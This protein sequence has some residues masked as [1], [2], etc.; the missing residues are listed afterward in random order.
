M[1]WRASTGDAVGKSGI[2]MLK[3]ARNA[4]VVSQ[5]DEA[6]S[7]LSLVES[8]ISAD[9]YREAFAYVE[10]EKVR[11]SSIDRI[12]RLA[13][14]VAVGPSHVLH[15]QIELRPDGYLLLRECQCG[16]NHLCAHGLALVLHLLAMLAVKKQRRQISKQFAEF[17]DW[18]V[19]GYFVR[20]PFKGDAVALAQRLT[21]SSIEELQAYWMLLDMAARSAKPLLPPELVAV[22]VMQLYRNASWV[23][24]RAAMDAM[25]RR[26]N[27]V[28]QEK[29]KIY[30]KPDHNQVFGVYRVQRKGGDL[31]PYE[32]ALMGS[33]GID[34]GCSCPD[35]A[36]NALHFC[37]HLGAVLGH[38]YA[39]KSRQQRFLTSAGTAVAQVRW[40]PPLGLDR[41][42][43]PLQGLLLRDGG[44]V[45]GGGFPRDRVSQE[46]LALFVQSA[47]GVWRLKSTPHVDTNL[48]GRA[49]L[50]ENLAQQ[51]RRTRKRWLIDTSVLPML[52]RESE[53]IAWP[54]EYRMQARSLAKKN[55]L[56]GKLYP[57]QK[58]GVQRALE[59]GRFLLGD[60]M[61]LGKT[62]QGISWAE[63]LLKGAL[64]RRVV[65]ICPA[66][67]KEQWRREWRVASGRQV[68]VVEGWP[69]E[70]KRIY[71]S[72]EKVLLVNYELLLRDFHQIQAIA[73][74]AVILDEAQRIKNYATQTAQLVKRLTPRFRL[75]LTGTPME[76]RVA[77]LCSLMD[78]VDNGAM[79]P[80]WRIDAELAYADGFGAGKSGVQG[81]NLVRE[82]LRP[83]FLRRRRDEVLTQLPPR[84]D[85][86]MAVEVT[87]EQLSIHGLYAHKV[88]KLMK[89]TENRPLTPEEHLL[90]MSYLTQMRIVSNG[91]AQFEF[92]DLWPSLKGDTS[93]GK[94]IPS[95]CSPKLGVFRSL[96]EGFLPQN[97]VK[98]VIFSQWQRMLHLAHWAIHD[99]LAESGTEAVFFTGGESQ[100]RRTENIV[101][102]HDDPSV[103]LFFA[104]DAGGVGLNLQKA[105][106]VCFNLELPWNPAVLEQRVGRI[107]RLGQTEPVQI[108]NLI[109]EGTIE[110]RITALVGR[111]R[112]LFN[113]LFDGTSNEVVFDD[114][115]NFY[116]QMGEVMREFSPAGAASSD[117]SDV[118]EDVENEDG[119]VTLDAIADEVK[120]IAA[121]TQPADTASNA[122][123]DP[124]AVVKRSLMDGGISGR[125]VEAALSQEFRPCGEPE[126]NHGKTLDAPSRHEQPL[127]DRSAS[128]NADAGRV[129][130]GGDCPSL[131]DDLAEAFRGIR[132]QKGAAGAIRLEA[133]GSSAK[134][135]ADVFRGLASMF[136]HAAQ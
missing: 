107:Y 95:L 42:D 24:K 102:F 82:R 100:K 77:E 89:I 48:L 46:L 53:R 13:G 111:K 62:F 35:Y 71:A 97:N 22:H 132:I 47:D 11:F 106:S 18:L 45:K 120:L 124:G 10:N 104:T 19:E 21:I 110:E 116:R 9:L 43:D 15:V 129:L 65:V 14:E 17:P 31:R 56:A 125:D 27:A 76:N 118:A 4:A 119:N 130:R 88:A 94:R 126:P 49:R 25:L 59:A 98:I 40:V 109:T 114:K 68:K 72:D 123:S 50:I 90:L 115:E 103:R 60:D 96:I 128:S 80:Y 33:H 105:A 44:S 1:K 63:T 92:A 39:R 91:L 41:V 122:G 32:V 74:D 86:P 70:R 121:G 38:F 67:L 8:Q 84:T 12:G 79:G 133:E 34:G 108:F 99:L 112:A 6:S 131:P 117:A 127:D 81:L 66:P 135:L 3:T 87:E 78:W 30:Q 29:I 58:Q 36:R 52:E 51:I 16:R 57:Y 23:I 54:Q 136:D 93:P 83:F 55:P 69:E 85:T 28:D 73:G 75:I 61:G 37:K 101:R 113:E 7:N 2:N 20:L 134:L 5:P 26:M 64:A